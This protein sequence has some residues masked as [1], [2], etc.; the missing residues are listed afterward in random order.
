M[1]PSKYCILIAEDNHIVRYAAARA[2]GQQGYCTVEAQDGLEAL[3]KA[4]VYD[5]AIQ[6]LVTNVRMPNMYGHELARELKVSRPDLKVLI[7]SAD[8]EDDFPPEARAHDF[9][10]LKPVD[11]KRLVE[12]VAKLI[13]QDGDTPSR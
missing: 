5:G 9:A 6:V 7:V 10:L 4:A 1:D 3:Q 13:G 2:L 12:E 11:S 8:H